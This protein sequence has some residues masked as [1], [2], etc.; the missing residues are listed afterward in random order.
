MRT[1]TRWVPLLALAALA[2]VA[3]A[4]S[5]TA[6]FMFDD[7]P[8][9]L[10]NSNIRQLW[11][12]SVTLTA[13]P[14]S[15]LGGRPVVSLS[16][17][18]N[19]AVGGL[20]VRGYHAFNVI[21]HF[22]SALILLGIAR[23]TLALS[24][25]LAPAAPG[26]ALVVAAVWLVHPVQT[27]AVTYVTQRTELLMGL[28]YLSTLYTAIRASHG[29]RSRFWETAAIV[30]CAIGMGCKE[31]MVTAPVMVMLY[32]RV[33]LYPSW[34]VAWRR[35]RVLYVGLVATWGVLATLLVLRPGHH[36]VVLM[37]GGRSVFE[38]RVTPWEYLRTQFG[39]VARYLVLAVWP[40]G[41]CLDYGIWVARTTRDVLPGAIVVAALVGATAWAFRRWPGIGFLGASFLLL[42]APSSTIVPILTETMA[43]RRMHL[44]LAPVIT[45]LVIA[46]Y[47]LGRPTRGAFR[48]G[49]VLAVV[50]ILSALTVQRNSDYRS[51]VSIWS[52]ATRK[53]PSNPRAHNNLGNA[54]LAAGDDDGAFREL[55][56]AV[57]LEPDY[58]E[59]HYNL[60]NVY[61]RNGQRAEAARSYGEALR[62]DPELAPAHLNLGS[63]WFDEGRFDEAIV[64]YSEVL[65]LEPDSEASATIRQWL[66][67][68][69]QH[70]AA[71][72]PAT[73]GTG[74][75]N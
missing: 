33:F 39:V 65:R 51:E 47:V 50:G 23:R 74:S 29:P 58:A 12:P 1:A 15:I 75:G 18:L 32:D 17:A 52:D 6:P 40:R 37:S 16:L 61:F 10:N 72:S 73:D 54:L 64:H 35:R 38:R 14:R 44:P 63:L 22:L 24:P 2:V 26:L 70:L 8:A 27:D 11:P 56:E 71:G 66:E 48:L 36:F 57:R 34:A 41:L 43:E 59:A 68:A 67:K 13:P 4:N 69:R 53:V 7:R 55:T 25:R 45:A 9:I 46:A 21:V 31:V 28:F 60:G 49:L 42:L 30:S 3:W 20:D 62:I 5:L 19:Y